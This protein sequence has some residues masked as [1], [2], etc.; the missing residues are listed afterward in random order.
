MGGASSNN[1][2]LV[3]PGGTGNPCMQLPAGI[4][5][6]SLIPPAV[7]LELWLTTS[8]LGNQAGWVRVL[9]FGAH[10]TSGW[11]ANDRSISF[12]R[13]ATTNG[14]RFDNWNAVSTDVAS[15]GTT[16]SAPTFN[17]VTA[18]HVVLVLYNGGTAYIYLNGVLVTTSTGNGVYMPDGSSGELNYIGFGSDISQPALVGSIAELRIWQGALQQSDVLAHFATGPQ[19]VFGKIFR[20]RNDASYC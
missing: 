18:M 12:G 4:L 8:T 5:G 15:T 14:F 16:I 3:L 17:G 19:V 2:Q 13:D 9:Q 6:T 7:S 10:S 20:L 1:G 11:A